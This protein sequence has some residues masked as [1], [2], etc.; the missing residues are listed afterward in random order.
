MATVPALHYAT[1]T[2]VITVSR[3]DINT[4]SNVTCSHSVSLFSAPVC[5]VSIAAS[6]AAS[7]W[8]SS[9]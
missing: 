3:P 4:S 5:I 6:N 8:S 2:P 9:V 1:H 7:L